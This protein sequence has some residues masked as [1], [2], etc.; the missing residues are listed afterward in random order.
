MRSDNNPTRRRPLLTVAVIC[1][2]H[3]RFLRDCLEGIIAQRIDFEME[4]VVVDDASTDGSRLIIEEYMSRHPGMFTPVFHKENIY[5]QG[6]SPIMESVLPNVRGK[7]L[8]FC[9]GDDFWTY[10]EKLRTQVDFLEK[11]PDYSACCHH[12]VVKDE[13]DPH[14]AQ[15]MFNLRHSRRLDV[16]DLLI[17]PQLQT[18]TLMLRSDIFLHDE[19]FHS[20]FSPQHFN[21]V[22][23][24]LAVLHAGK[25]YGFREWRSTYRIHGGG[26]SQNVTDEEKVSRHCRLMRR[27][28]T[29]Y[30]G[31]YRGLDKMYLTHL[32][33][34]DM[35]AEATYMR[36]DGRYLAYIGRMIKAFRF[37]PKHFLK[38]YYH[39]YR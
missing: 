35:L 15:V 30:G 39:A 9:E 10:P 16:Y 34:R 11:H 26:T 17:E 18:A 7:Y 20:F 1:Y 22:A 31:R 6:R 5:S 14:R 37:S 36:R 27:L 23:L 12:Y 28:G 38:T 33:M 29:L 8:I 25:V 24:F 19:D 3:E 21:D 2:N 4:V 13:D 32:R